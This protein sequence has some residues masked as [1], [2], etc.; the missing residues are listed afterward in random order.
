MQEIDLDSFT[1]IKS[2]GNNEEKSLLLIQDKV[3]N[4]KYVQTIYDI[5]N[6]SEEAQKKYI[7]DFKQIIKISQYPGFLPIFG[8]TLKDFEKKSNPTILA[9]D[10]SRRKLTDIL[11]KWALYYQ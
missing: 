11:L 4:I 7:E 6:L 3:T 10:T 1:I 9:I 8:F 2:I 5:T